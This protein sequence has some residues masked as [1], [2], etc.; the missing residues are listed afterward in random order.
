M[1]AWLPYLLTFV[2]GAVI[3][4]VGTFGYIIWYFKGHW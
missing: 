2:V 3:G 1:P 4:V